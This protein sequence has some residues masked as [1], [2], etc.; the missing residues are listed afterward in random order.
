MRNHLRFLLFVPVIN[1]LFGNVLS[2][3][4]LYSLEGLEQLGLTLYVGLDRDYSSLRRR[5][6]SGS[7][8]FLLFFILIQS[9]S[10]MIIL[11]PIEEYRIIIIQYILITNK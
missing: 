9:L 6:G 1:K 8:R 10:Q 2:Q 4:L 3:F 11:L 7:L 5:S